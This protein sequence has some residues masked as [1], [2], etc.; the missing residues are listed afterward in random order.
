M[1]VDLK[2]GSITLAQVVR[3]V[4]GVGQARASASVE[5]TGISPERRVGGLGT[6]QRE[7]LLAESA[8]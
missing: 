5:R 8:T 4:P 1:L 7:Q 6:R 3:A 2:A